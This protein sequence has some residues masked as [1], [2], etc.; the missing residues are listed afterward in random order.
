MEEDID[1]IIIGQNK[2]WKQHA[3]IGKRNNQSFTA[4]PHSLLIQM[5]TYKAEKH[6][7]TVML[8]EE[9][10]TSKASFLDNDE[11]P[12]YDQKSQSVVFSG[13]RIK[14]GLYLS[15]MRLLCIMIIPR[16]IT[17]PFRYMLIYVR[18][19]FVKLFQLHLPQYN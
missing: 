17:L 15:K 5:I 19:N 8:T 4:I 7:I 6:G 13:K 10:Y 9:S 16:I 2:D 1:T 12:I 3:A 11:I 18:R 14:R